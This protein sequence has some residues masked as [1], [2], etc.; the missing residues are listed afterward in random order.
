M[1]K[2]CRSK[3][4]LIYKCTN[5]QAAAWKKLALHLNCCKDFGYLVS[6]PVIISIHLHLQP[7]FSCHLDLKDLLNDPEPSMRIVASQALFRVQM[8]GAEPDP[9]QTFFR[10]WKL[11]GCL[12]T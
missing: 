2:F 5:F 6:G 7:G 12:P 11:M 4:E 8:V 9:R 3:L 10:L 1:S